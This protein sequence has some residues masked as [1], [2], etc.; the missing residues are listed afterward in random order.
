MVGMGGHDDSMGLLSHVYNCSGMK[1]FFKKTKQWER[2][3][4]EGRA[5]AK[6]VA[7]YVLQTWWMDMCPQWDQSWYDTH[8]YATLNIEYILCT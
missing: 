5:A 3:W 1:C 6:L 4:G 8:L 7:G 2:I